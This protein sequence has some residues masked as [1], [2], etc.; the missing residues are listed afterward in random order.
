VRDEPRPPG[1]DL[2]HELRQ[3]TLRKGVRLD[4]IRLDECAEPRLVPD[5]AADR[6]LLEPGQAELRE[7]AIGE[8]SDADDPDRGEIARPA[9]GGEHRGE[10]V[11]E[12]LG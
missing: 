2:A 12:S 11:D 9:L 7:P 3:D 10:L 4:L 8:V 1:R 5:V 6:P